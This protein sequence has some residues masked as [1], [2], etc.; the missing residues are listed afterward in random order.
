M[1]IAIAPSPSHLPSAKSQ[2]Y[3]IFDAVKKAHSIKLSK[4]A[5]LNA[6]AV[7]LGY[8]DWGEFTAVTLHAHNKNTNEF[9]FTPETLQA[10]SERIC[11]FLNQMLPNSNISESWC[12]SVCEYAISESEFD[13]FDYDDEVEEVDEDE[14]THVIETEPYTYKLDDDIFVTVTV[15][16]SIPD[17]LSDDEF[18]A[19]VAVDQ[20]L[21]TFKFI[22]KGYTLID[23]RKVEL[24][25]TEGACMD[26]RYVLMASNSY[27][28]MVEAF[29]WDNDWSRLGKTLFGYLPILAVAHPAF[30]QNYYM[31]DAEI[32]LGNLL[33]E[34]FQLPDD[35]FVPDDFETNRPPIALIDFLVINKG[36]PCA[37]K[38]NAIGVIAEVARAVCDQDVYTENKVLIALDTK[39]NVCRHLK[40]EFLKA[41]NI[42]ENLVEREVNTASLHT[43]FINQGF[44]HLEKNTTP[45]PRMDKVQFIMGDRNT[46]Y[47]HVGAVIDEPTTEVSYVHN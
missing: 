13:L 12:L 27:T 9:I 29:D 38:I 42:P 28:T 47:E 15:K 33:R 36:N 30:K 34:K 1:R 4:P 41:Y 18:L 31:L 19:S 46:K 14:I 21:S 2:A 45:N 40:A 7:C 35:Y 24:F 26:V 39:T 20:H 43:H 16:Q 3:Q 37:N 17:A 8:K 23:D 22:L 32:H 10:I 6:W 5:F 11:V 44:V 25:L